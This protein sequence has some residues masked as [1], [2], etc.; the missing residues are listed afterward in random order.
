MSTR[1]KKN[2][3]IDPLERGKS[4]ATFEIDR[5]MDD[6]YQMLNYMRPA[7]SKA[8]LDFIE[9]FIVP[10]GATQDYAGNYHVTVLEKDGTKSPVLWSSHTDTV[11]STSGHQKLFITEN[12]IVS[13]DGGS[14]LG[15]D[16]TAGIWL[17]TRMIKA[18][19]PGL[20][21]F[22]RQEEIGGHGSRAIARLSQDIR[23]KTDL[24]DGAQTP[25]I[26]EMLEFYLSNNKD[27]LEGIKYAIAFD[28]KNTTSIITFQGTRCCSDEF[29]DS[30]ALE[31]ADGE[32][33][34]LEKDRG[35]TF[36]DTA[37]Y[38]ALIPECTNVSVGYY[39]QHTRHETLNTFWIKK[40][41]A[42]LLQFDWRNLVEHRKVD[43]PNEYAY[44]SYHHST[45]D[46]M[47]W[48]EYKD[49]WRGS[50]GGNSTSRFKPEPNEERWLYFL[51]KDHPGIITEM[52]EE[53][54]F[55]YDTLEMEIK[56]RGGR[57]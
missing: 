19:V 15:A 54:G 44:R 11:H 26:K 43:D 39:S 10:L 14:C 29:A 20:Y 22:H 17:M 36:T 23:K 16:D 1:P 56:S 55:D 30:L 27:P 53:F 28:R 8:E 21:I 40:L 3:S 4:L 24:L 46:D 33:I 18:K 51:V 25:A 45:Y 50:G 48:E 57:T 49:Y 2:N 7:G 32:F 42:S 31:L 12:G 6:L 35:G 9:K 13:S 38:T 5:S 37:N 34:K 52:L 47:G 41:L